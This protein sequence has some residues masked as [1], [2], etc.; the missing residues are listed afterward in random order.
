MYSKNYFIYFFICFSNF[1]FS[2]TLVA[3]KTFKGAIN[4]KHQIK[5]TLNIKGNGDVVGYY[6]YESQ[7]INIPLKGKLI[8]N[9]IELAE[10]IEFSGQFSQGFKGTLTND[11]MTGVWADSLKKQKYKFALSLEQNRTP[12]KKLQKLE[13]SYLEAKSDSTLTKRL[14]LVYVSANMFK[15]ELNI[16]SKK[17][18]MGIIIGLIEFKNDQAT[19]KD[20][21]CKA[22][23]LQV[24][25]NNTLQVKE[26]NCIDYHGMQCDFM[27]SYIKE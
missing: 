4:D 23:K 12:N 1:I 3:I 22:I 21:D 27:G 20:A 2:N 10:N 9:K 8:N 6:Y 11:A 15:F 7:K 26:T 5:M 18:C 19:Y 14:K 24:Q 13:G 17:G 16:S 25:C